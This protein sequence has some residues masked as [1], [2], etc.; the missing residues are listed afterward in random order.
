MG[1]F[2]RLNRI[3]VSWLATIASLS[4]TSCLKPVHISKIKHKFG[5]TNRSDTDAQPCVYDETISE[6]KVADQYLKSIATAIASHNPDTFKGSFAIGK[7]CIYYRADSKLNAMAI[8]KKN[9]IYFGS[10]TINAAASDA[11]IA[12]ILAH[13]LAHLTMQTEHIDIA[14]QLLL[15]PEWQKLIK[16][17]H[18]RGTAV[19]SEITRLNRALEPANQSI[20]AA[21]Q[22][23]IAKLVPG[24]KKRAKDLGYKRLD[25]SS[26]LI[27][28]QNPP[29]NP[30]ELNIFP[31]YRTIAFADGILTADGSIARFNPPS[32]THPEAAKDLAEYQKSAADFANEL[33][34][35]F[36]TDVEA[37]YQQYEKISPI[38]TQ[39]DEAWSRLTKLQQEM[40]DASARLDPKGIRHNWTEQEADEVGFELY[41]R[42]GFRWSDFPWLFARQMMADELERCRKDHIEKNV[43]PTRGDSSHPAN[44]WR[45]FNVLVTEAQLHKDEYAPFVNNSVVNLTNGKLSEIKRK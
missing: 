11:E 34:R 20:N 19:N 8:L 35:A 4:V 5:E 18:E 23:L 2:A 24:Q 38:E 1:R 25:L 33:K 7:I 26:M 42:A 32:R 43:E 27:N 28:T 3:F 22:K 15:N 37:L 10:D 14:P 44:C 36:P 13:E 31:G 17:A 39:K 40:D 21:E 6:N 41:L 9:M 45:V 30:K 29:M 16:G 12:A